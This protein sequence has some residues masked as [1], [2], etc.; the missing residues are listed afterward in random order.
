MQVLQVA[1]RGGVLDDSLRLVAELPKSQSSM[2]SVF[3]H[4]AGI[5]P[6]RISA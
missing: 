6:D 5:A 2:E 1:E 4:A 3:A